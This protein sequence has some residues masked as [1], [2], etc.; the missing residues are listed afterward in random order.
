MNEYKIEIVKK[1]Q[2]CNIENSI[3]SC[4]IRSNIDV[5]GVA[6]IIGYTYNLLVLYQVQNN[7]DN[8]VY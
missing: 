7:D 8:N 1:L 6:L 5:T 2:N 3:I 4:T